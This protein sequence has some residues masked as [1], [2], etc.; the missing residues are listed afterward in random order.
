MKLASLLVAARIAIAGVIPADYNHEHGRLQARHFPY[1]EVD[2]VDH[3]CVILRSTEWLA[4]SLISEVEKISTRDA[5]RVFR[6]P[7]LQNGPL[8]VSDLS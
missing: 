3:T 2:S 8:T 1:R 5:V 6:E 7:R 4:H